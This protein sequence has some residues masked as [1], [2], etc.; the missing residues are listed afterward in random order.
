MVAKGNKQGTLK[1]CSHCHKLSSE[2]SAVR[3]VRMSDGTHHEVTLQAPVCPSCWFFFKL[4]VRKCEEQ[5]KG[6][7]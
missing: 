2:L 7:E 6:R 3:M 5:G 4:M 1:R